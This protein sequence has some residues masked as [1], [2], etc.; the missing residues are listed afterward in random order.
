M[1]LITENIDDLQY[2]I[3]EVDGIKQ[4]YI[5]GI[6][7][8][9]NVKNRNGRRYPLQTLQ[10]EVGRY[11][12]EQINKNRAVGEL[13]HPNGPTINLDKA[14]H[15][16]IELFQEGENYIG[17]ALIL[18][19]PNGKIVKNL[20]DAK[21]QLGVSTR[22]MGSIKNVNG[23]DVVQEDFILATI[24]IVS[25]PSAPDAFVNGIMENKEYFLENGILVEK[26]LQTL[27]EE[28]LLEAFDELMD[29]IRKF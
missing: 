2:L 11:V 12:R 10:K 22:G 23:V 16:I 18:D 4:Y 7:L 13:G 3:E 28:I 6:F 29:R 17:K 19:T 15:K 26:D 27:R 5:K 20:L 8:Q 9:G 1:K 21:V 24:D 14:S 25:D